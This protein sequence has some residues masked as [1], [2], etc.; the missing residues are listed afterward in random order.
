MRQSPESAGKNVPTHP[1]D[2]KGT[3]FTAGASVAF[4]CI[5]DLCISN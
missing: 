1:G 4:G 5:T 3:A 2:L